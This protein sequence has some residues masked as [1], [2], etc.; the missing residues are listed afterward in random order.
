MAVTVGFEPLSQANGCRSARRDPRDSA[1]VWH[2]C[3]HLN[4]RS[5]RYSVTAALPL[6]YR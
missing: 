3:A 1:E 5:R 4:T 2:M 6:R